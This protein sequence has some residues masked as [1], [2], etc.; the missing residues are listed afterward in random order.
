M[1]DFHFLL[2]AA[3]HVT[4]GEGVGGIKFKKSNSNNGA[5]GQLF[6]P[7]SLG[8]CGCKLG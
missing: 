1:N 5:S 7:Y 2:V 6:G 8:V 3:N 4:K